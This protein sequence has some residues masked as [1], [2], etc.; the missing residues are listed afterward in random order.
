MAA[1]WIKFIIRSGVGYLVKLEGDTPCM[2]TS[3]LAAALF[4]LEDAVEMK[5]RLEAL[6][7]AAECLASIGEPVEVVVQTR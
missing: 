2:D 6:G 7:F 4:D 3:K 5:I 1:R